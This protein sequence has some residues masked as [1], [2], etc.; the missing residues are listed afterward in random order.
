M[1]GA[2]LSGKLCAQ[3][4]VQVREHSIS[5]LTDVW[6]AGIILFSSHLDYELSVIELPLYSLFTLTSRKFIFVSE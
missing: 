5:S 6:F 1:E 2:V 4:I 3:A